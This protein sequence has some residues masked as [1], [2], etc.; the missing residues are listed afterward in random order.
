VKAKRFSAATPISVDTWIALFLVLNYLA[1][2]LPWV[3]VKRCVF[4]IIICR[5]G[6]YI[7]SDRLVCRPVYP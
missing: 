3:Q 7:F 6:V 2:I 4:I 1:N 5:C